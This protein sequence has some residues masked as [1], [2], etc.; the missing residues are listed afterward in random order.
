MMCV[1][2]VYFLE[3]HSKRA[4]TACRLKW[5]TRDPIMADIILNILKVSLA[6][7]ASSRTHQQIIAE[8]LLITFAFIDFLV[9]YSRH[10]ITFDSARKLLRYLLCARN[11]LTVIAPSPLDYHS[12]LLFFP[13]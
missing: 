4:K 2:Y 12:L 9:E 1:S 13:S 5:K 7:L 3:K 6:E 8:N 11:F 10:T